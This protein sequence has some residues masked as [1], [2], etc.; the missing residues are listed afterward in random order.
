MNPNAQV[1]DLIMQLMSRGRSGGMPMNASPELTQ[2]LAH[3]QAG[4]APP[5]MRGRPSADVMQG[6]GSG[7]AAINDPNFL[8]NAQEFDQQI[9]DIVNNDAE[10]MAWD[11]MMGRDKLPLS[12]EPLPPELQAQLGQGNEPSPMD[13]VGIPRPAPG[14]GTMGDGNQTFIWYTNPQTGKRVRLD[15]PFTDDILA[16][17]AM[18]ELH[19]AGMSDELEISPY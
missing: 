6:P 11:R 2:Y 3:A 14:A 9:G 8:A 19:D 15:G 13:M 4:S 12:N 10:D 16:A 1:A 5:Q 7:H 17:R 18:R